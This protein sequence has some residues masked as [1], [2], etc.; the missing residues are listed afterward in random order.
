MLPDELPTAFRTTL[1]ALAVRLRPGDDLKRCIGLLAS[2]EGI[3]AGFI[4]SAVG[5]VRSAVLRFA[6]SETGT[7]ITGPM[8]IVSLV[9][10]IGSAGSHL[11][12]SV[13]DGSG[14]T[15]GGHLLDGTT[16]FTTAELV[17]GICHDL[18]FARESDE[19][20][21]YRELVIRPAV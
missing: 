19:G 17:V 10:T 8:E 7:E 12:L 6:G 16:I 3:A 5:S 20:T 14:V 18:S 11:H 21:G 2:T 9:G 1:T 4:V 13:S 15:R